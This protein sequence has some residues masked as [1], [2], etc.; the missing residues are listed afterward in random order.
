MKISNDINATD[1]LTLARSKPRSAQSG[2]SFS[3]FLTQAVSNENNT[4]Q[5]SGASQAA[6]QVGSSTE[7]NLSPVWQQTSALLD[8]LESYG[9]ALGDG[10]LTL[11]DIEPL[12]NQLA[13][14]AEQLSQSLGAGEGDD[15]SSL[16]W[17]AVG[18]AQAEVYKFKRGDY[19]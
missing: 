14:G 6:G 2:A 11:K 18:R 9:Q 10:S 17:E 4:A 19:V 7:S 8:T 15:L 1:A 5:G 13:Q 3:D 16:A 12:A